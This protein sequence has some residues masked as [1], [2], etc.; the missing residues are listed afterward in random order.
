MSH[1]TFLRALARVSPL[2]YESCQALEAA[3]D[4][5]EQLERELRAA[6]SNVEHMRGVVS[7]QIALRVEAQARAGRLGREARR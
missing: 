7:R 6:G 4:Y 3:A 5:I 2:S 1:E